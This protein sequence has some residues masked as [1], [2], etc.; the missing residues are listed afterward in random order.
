MKNVKKTVTLMLSTALCVSLLM[1]SCKKK[2]KDEPTPTPTTTGGGNTDQEL[3]TTMK[4]MINNGTTTATYVY[5][6]PDGDGGI[7]AFYGPGTNSTSAQT[8]SVI[9]LLANKNY[10]VDILLLDESNAE[11]DT[12]SNEV[13]E[14][15]AD[16][17]FF[18][19]QLTPS[20][21]PNSFVTISG[22]NLTINYKDTDGAATPR[23]I[24]LQTQ[25]ITGA[26]T[27]TKKE[28]VI[29]LKHQPGVK[30]GTYSP[31]EV[32]VAVPFK[33]KIN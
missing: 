26:A 11:I 28:L 22:T 10:T 25:W 9:N 27:T 16:H 2:K 29:E 31:G 13:E 14:E 30:N 17:M 23:P 7:A 8:D 18:F 21:L 1:V 4:V 32:D 3:I 15:G 12:I 5:K 19:N 33:I 6:D 20:A 24:G